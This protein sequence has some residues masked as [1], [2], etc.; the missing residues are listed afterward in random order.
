MIIL[1]FKEKWK[2]DKEKEIE[3]ERRAREYGEA[4]VEEMFVST[5]EVDVEGTDAGTLEIDRGVRSAKA[6]VY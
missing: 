3:L 6:N 4:G 2:R 1:K 5:R